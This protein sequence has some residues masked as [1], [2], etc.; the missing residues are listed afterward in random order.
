MIS[1]SKKILAS[2]LACIIFASCC[3]KN[4]NDGKIASAEN[5][6]M[7]LIDLTKMG[8]NMAYASFY[9]FTTESENYI[10]KKLKIEG[11]FYLAEN[12]MTQKK[13]NY[14][15]IRDANECCAQGIEFA[16]QGDEVLNLD[17]ETQIEVTGT[18]EKYT[19]GTENFLRLSN[20]ECIIKN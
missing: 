6:S 14:V 18:F 19:E 2:S 4:E 17:D 5:E 7:E 12:P 11:E 10:G 15:I 1:N 13:Y 16:L 3:K 8:K 9:Q 20:S